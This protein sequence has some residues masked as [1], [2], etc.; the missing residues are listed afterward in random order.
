[1]LVIFVEEGTLQMSLLPSLQRRQCCFN[2]FSEILGGR[3]SQQQCQWVIFLI[4]QGKVV[5]VFDLVSQQLFDLGI[6]LLGYS[7]IA[8]VFASPEP[9]LSFHFN[10]F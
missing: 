2:F 5:L 3:Q 7:K 9:L 1:M 4:G 6:G 8:V 10:K